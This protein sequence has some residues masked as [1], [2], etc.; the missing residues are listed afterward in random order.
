MIN[1]IFYFLGFILSLFFATKFVI[2][3]IKT[4]EVIKYGI[5]TT[6]EIIEMP[7][8]NAKSTVMVLYNNKKYKLILGKNE[9]IQNGYRITDEIPVIYYDKMDKL[10][11]K[12]TSGELGIYFGIAFYLLPLF[13]LYQLIKK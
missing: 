5:S 6:A 10:V 9:C 11:S 13:C 12:G 1:R 2:D 8:C 4:N 7:V 3:S